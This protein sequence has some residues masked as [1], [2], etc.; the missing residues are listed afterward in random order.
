MIKINVYLGYR[1]IDTV[2]YD[3][4][5]VKGFKSLP[6]MKEYIKNGLVNHDNYN[7]AIWLKVSA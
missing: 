5:F 6:E 3:D 2:F 4:D 1:V 7:P